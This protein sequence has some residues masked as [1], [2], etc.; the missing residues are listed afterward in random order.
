MAFY[1]RVTMSENLLASAWKHPDHYP[2]L[3]QSDG[4]YTFPDFPE[5]AAFGF[6]D[7]VQDILR[8]AIRQR[9][10]KNHLVPFPSDPNKLGGAVIMVSTAPSNPVA[11][12]TNED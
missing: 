1:G 2:A 5:I 3:M 7:A 4:S 8:E 11:I 6:G 12:E 9:E 10:L